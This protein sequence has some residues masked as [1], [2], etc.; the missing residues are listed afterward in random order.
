MAAPGVA[1]V[2]GAGPGLGTAL[3]RRFAG[4]GMAVAVARRDRAALAATVDRI[5]PAARP[6]ACDAADERE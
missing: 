2:V 4:A 1:I 6:Y 3:A 5:G